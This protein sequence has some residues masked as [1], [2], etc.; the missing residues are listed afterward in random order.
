MDLAPEE[1]VCG[2]EEKKGRRGGK[3]DASDGKRANNPERL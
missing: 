1:G 3:P 2:G